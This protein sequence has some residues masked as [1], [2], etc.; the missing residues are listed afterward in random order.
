MLGFSRT[1]KASPVPNENTVIANNIALSDLNSARSPFVAP[2]RLQNSNQMIG[3]HL[4]W[5]R[6]SSGERWSVY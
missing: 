6:E 3:S 1:L 5:S 2:P 4:G